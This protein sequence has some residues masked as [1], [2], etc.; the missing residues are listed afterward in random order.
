MVIILADL[1]GRTV[2]CVVSSLITSQ[3]SDP[4]KMLETGLHLAGTWFFALAGISIV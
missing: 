4:L 2:A 3:V 1:A